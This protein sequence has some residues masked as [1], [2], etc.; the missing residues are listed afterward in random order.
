MIRWFGNSL[1]REFVDSG[2]CNIYAIEYRHHLSL[3][4][5]LN[6][7]HDTLDVVR[8]RDN[9]IR[10]ARQLATE[11]DPARIVGPVST[12]LGVHQWNPGQNGRRYAVLMRM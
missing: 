6:V 4:D 11:P 2:R 7:S 8:D 10:E 1:I 5:L 9:D 12:M 3:R